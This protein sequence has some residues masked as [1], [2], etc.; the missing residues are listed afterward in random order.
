MSI[1]S[2]VV[3][4][5]WK[6]YHS[7]LVTKAG[8]HR[9]EAIEKML[10]ALG[11]R[12]STCPSSSR[13]SYHGCYVGG[14]VEH[15]L[16]TLR[17]AMRIRKAVSQGFEEIQEESIVFAC[18]LHDLGKIG[19][20][21]QERYIPQTN[22]YYREKGNLFEINQNVEYSTIQHMSLF[23]LQSFSVECSWHEWQAILLADSSYASNDMENYRM[24]ETPLALLVTQAER[25]AC[26]QTKSV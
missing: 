11:E 19:T 4:E 10:D 25:L 18:L 2:E 15:S 7:L 23:L 5:N 26:L 13:V 22:S 6:K 1:D 9:S 16:L 14:L 8:S 17:N 12:I 3:I 20:L 24:R 21:D